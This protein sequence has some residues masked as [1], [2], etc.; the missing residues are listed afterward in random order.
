[1]PAAKPLL[2]YLAPAAFLA[3][4]AHLSWLAGAHWAV[5]GDDFRLLWLAGDFWTAGGN[6]YTEEFAQTAAEK[7]ADI[8]DVLW[9]AGPNWFPVAA[10][11]S[12]FDPLTGARGWFF[13]N[14]ALL[15]GASALNVAAFRKMA[16][17]SALFGETE[18]ASCLKSLSPLTL[19]LLHAGFITLTE[20]VGGAFALG[21]ASPLVYFG[22]SLLLYGAAAKHDL[23]GAGGVALVMLQPPIGLILIAALGLS[24]Y[25]RR[26]IVLG[27]ILAFLMAVPVL[28]VTPGVDIATALIA[29][30]GQNPSGSTETAAGLRALLSTAGAP[31]LGAMFYFLLALAAVSAAGLAGRKR[32]RALKP[33]D[34]LMIAAGAALAIA[35]LHTPDFVLAGLLLLYAAALRPP[36]G[37]GLIAAAFLIWRAGD[38]PGFGALDGGV[39][40]S[41]GAAA[42]FALLIGASFFSP[43]PMPV[44]RPAP[45]LGDNVVLWSAFI[46]KRRNA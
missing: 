43:A 21:A 15:L 42:I 35:P 3:G 38:L 13:F 22:A 46:K 4:M 40:A 6:P 29:G 41:L 5:P 31:D 7:F 26:A 18:F 39:Y 16:A 33:V 32:A 9:L 19:F 25:G 8:G 12:L 30:A 37:A 28:A 14:A 27:G 20:A 11:F 1:M 24:A 10:F 44:R 36:L 34:N 2:T 45:S 23:A 17:Q